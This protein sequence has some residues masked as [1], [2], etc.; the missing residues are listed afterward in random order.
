MGASQLK[1]MFVT[2]VRCFSCG[3]V[4]GLIHQQFMVKP[5]YIYTVALY[6]YIKPVYSVIIISALSRGF[7]F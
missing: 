7:V 4:P 3:L 1:I 2:A 5:T 6:I